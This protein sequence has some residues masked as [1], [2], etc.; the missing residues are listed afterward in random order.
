MGA[1]VKRSFNLLNAAS[2][3]DF[4]AKHKFPFGFV[5]SVNS[6]AISAKFS[7]FFDSTR[8]DLKRREL[9]FCLQVS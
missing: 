9:Q 4:H 1:C 3:S 5:S 6:V 2:A 7:I 8:L